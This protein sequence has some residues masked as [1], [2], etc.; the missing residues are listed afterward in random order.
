MKKLFTLLAA[1]LL[2]SCCSTHSTVDAMKATDD[3][4][5]LKSKTPTLIAT[6]ASNPIKI[7][8]VMTEAEWGK[9]WT[10]EMKP[11]FNPEAYNPP[12]RVK[13]INDAPFQEGQVK[14]LYDKD[15][16]Y[17]GVKVKDTDVV[18]YAKKEQDHLYRTGDIIEIFLKSKKAPGHWELYGAPNGLRTTMKQYGVGGYCN[19]ILEEFRDEMKVGA[20]VQGT[21]NNF[22]DTDEGYVLEFAIPFKM[23]EDVSGVKVNNTGEWTILVSRYNYIVD[24]EKQ[25]SSYPA[26]PKINYHHKE[27]YADLIFE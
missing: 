21:L 10:Y 4:F 17:V 11:C 3:A 15:T 20:T 9:P 7:D 14:V 16:L 19:D 18:Q 25:F 13:T 8:G 26:L 6:R 24:Q 12:K 5:S 1:A 27:Y 2:T 23:M 22:K